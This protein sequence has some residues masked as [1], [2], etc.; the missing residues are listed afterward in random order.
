MIQ[1]PPDIG[2][3]VDPT[4][5]WH[6]SSRY[7]VLRK[8]S[9]GK[10]H[11]GVDIAAPKG[12]E[13]YA[14]E[15]ATLRG[16]GS[17]DISGNYVTLNHPGKTYYSCYCHLDQVSSDLM[18]RGNGSAVNKGELLG[19]MGTTGRSTGPHLHF[20]LWQLT[21]RITLDCNDYVDKAMGGGISGLGGI[22]S[23]AYS[24]ANKGAMV[25]D[26]W[27]NSML[28]MGGIQ[29]IA[30]KGIEITPEEYQTEKPTSPYL[31]WVWV[32]VGGLLLVGIVSVI[33]V[34]GRK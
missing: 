12:T 20:G 9:G 28:G 14:P 26:E 17:D 8:I 34:K 31:K 18:N 23:F 33:I 22:G 3:M 32:G 10:A 5:S 7:G 15:I 27:L 30:E 24:T 16:I 11:G 1:P 19:Y 13:I 25:I 4:S 2:P 29:D 6:I 21:P